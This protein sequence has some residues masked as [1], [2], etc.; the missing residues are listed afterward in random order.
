MEESIPIF[1]VIP[2]YINNP[3]GAIIK[4]ANS[5]VICAENRF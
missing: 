5:S 3:L 2:L 4:N 1:D